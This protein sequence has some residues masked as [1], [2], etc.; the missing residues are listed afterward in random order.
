[1]INSIT[2]IS[3]RGFSQ[4]KQMFYNQLFKTLISVTV[5]YEKNRIAIASTILSV[6]KIKHRRQN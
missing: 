1:M 5:Y 4:L 6:L 3:R 2:I